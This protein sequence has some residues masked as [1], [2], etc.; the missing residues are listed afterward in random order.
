MGIGFAPYIDPLNYIQ[1]YHRAPPLSPILEPYLLDYLDWSL[2][3]SAELP[4]DSSD[5]EMVDNPE[6]KKKKKRP[7][8]VSH[9][10]GNRHVKLIIALGLALFFIL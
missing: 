10:D 4:K 8:S 6:E 7:G 3:E 2:V 5:D 9:Q 1:L